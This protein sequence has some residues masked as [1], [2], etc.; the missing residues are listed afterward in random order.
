MIRHRK[1]SG[2]P[3]A[4][5]REF[6]PVALILALSLVLRLYQ[7]SRQGL[8]IDE[9]YSVYLARLSL[10]EIVAGTA[11]DQHP[12]LY[13]MLLHAWMQVA[14]SSEFAVRFLSVGIGVT[15]VGV[16]YLAGRRIFSPAVGLWAAFLLAVSPMHIRYSQVTRMYVLLVLFGLLSVYLMGSWLKRPSLPRA[17]AYVL[18]TSAALYTQNFALFLLLFQ[19]LWVLLV[20]VTGRHWKMLRNWLLCQAVVGLLWLPWLPTLLMQI[21]KHRVSWIGPPTLQGI[22][23]TL[24]YLSSGTLPDR[25]G[26]PPQILTGLWIIA[27]VAACGLALARRKE[28]R[29]ETIFVLAWFAVPALTIAGLALRYPLYQDKQFLMLLPALMLLWAAGLMALAPYWRVFLAIGLLALQAYPLYDFYHRWTTQEWREAISYLEEHQRP[30]DAI[31][32]NPAASVIMLD[33]YSDGKLPIVGFPQD[34]DILVG[35]F[36]GEIT[37]PDSV[38]AKL[39]PLLDTYDRAWIVQFTAGFWDPEGLI[40]SWLDAHTHLE[41]IHEFTD[42]DLRLYELERT[43]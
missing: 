19:N 27:V 15:T 5:W 39:R 28:Q 18:V 25:P 33:Y 12:P 30:G 29:Q 32:L 38:N 4:G 20:S 22:Q 6:A 23:N 10:P 21:N 40:V 1:G 37:T 13:Y 11:A 3:Q 16:L 8:W 26:G 36:V 2:T 35:G 43:E 24:L 17:A 31:I 41:E 42:L 7:I 9:G 34:Y 14:G